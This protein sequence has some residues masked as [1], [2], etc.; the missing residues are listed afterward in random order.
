[1]TH[2]FSHVS[3]CFAFACAL[4]LVGC[5]ANVDLDHIDPSAKVD[6]A[7]AI[8][9]GEM[10][11]TL[12]DFLTDTTITGI[13]IRE[14]GIYQFEYAID[15]DRQF[16]KVDLTQ[17][18]SSTQKT[19]KLAEQGY[20]VPISSTVQLQFPMSVNLSNIN[21][22]S[23]I[24]NERLDKMVIDMA[25]F[26]SSFTN[27]FGL[28]WSE[29]QKIELILPASHFEREAGLTLDIPTAGY[30]FGQAI[31]I[32][33]DN[34]VLNLMK[35]PSATPS[36]NNV[37]STFTFDIRFTITPNTT[38]TPT[39]DSKFDYNFAVNFMDYSAIYGIFKE[40]NQMFDHDTLRIADIW[41]G[42]ESFKALR[43]PL[44][45]PQIKLDITTAIAA[46][47][48]AT[49]EYL[50]VQEEQTKEEKVAHNFDGVP[51]QT[52]YQKTLPN[53]LTVN[54]PIDATVTNTFKFGRDNGAL[55]DLLSIRP[56]IVM[57]RYNF[58]TWDGSPKQDQ[59]RLTKDTKVHM[60]ATITIP[61]QLNEGTTF[62]YTD[63]INA[64]LNQISLDSLVSNI[65]QIDSLTVNNLKLV[66][67]AK[68][69]IPFDITGKVAFLD[70][71]GNDLGIKIND[72]NVIKILGPTD[73]T[74]S[75]IN[76][77]GE[78]YIVVDI[79]Q[80]DLDLLSQ[81]QQIYFDL[82]LNDVD[83]DKLKNKGAV[84]PIALAEYQKLQLKVAVSADVA[85]YLKLEFG[86]K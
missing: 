62:G 19:L 77:P 45:D 85:A 78:A 71:S 73:Y 60:T 81:T 59:H 2:S 20:G 65:D 50:K 57:Y 67:T 42:W 12:G 79:D 18:V 25:E 6:M 22:A 58:V 33:V 70:A 48:I 35:D 15:Y 52:T 80:N 51:S 17:Y 44:Y 41:G 16:H 36:R 43:L 40:S 66:L 13:S 28:T 30:D 53:T 27:N 68:S 84:F 37:D 10:S 8:P 31:P 69:W 14:D 46:P 39:A 1:M 82:S 9:V 32:N 29:I 21:T 5:N 64:S 83:V 61:F 86:E 76:T 49:I 34:F 11:A 38:I 63:T 75:A 3:L 4:A 23:T 56:D 7:L 55:D 72:D 74:G 26:T 24:E 54:D 47:L